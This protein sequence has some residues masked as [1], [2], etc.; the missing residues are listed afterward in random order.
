MSILFFVALI[1]AEIF[2][3]IT[4][5]NTLKEVSYENRRMGPELVWLNLI[6]FFNFI[7]EFF[8]IARVADSLKAEFK[9]RNIVIEKRRPGYG[10]GMTYLFLSW[11]TIIIFFFSSAILGPFLAEF[12]ALPIYL[13]CF[14]CW[15]IYWG[16]ISKYKAMLVQNKTHFPLIEK[17][18]NEQ[19]NSEKLVKLHQLK[20]LLDAG[21]LTQKE[22]DEQ[23]LKILGT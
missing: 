11:I 16:R 1:V 8:I 12:V 6:P 21:A 19:I 3:L 22:F 20:Q 14:I 15:I 5:Q 4:L 18:S 7:W 2:Y 17:V 23:K 9:K 10:V 13:P